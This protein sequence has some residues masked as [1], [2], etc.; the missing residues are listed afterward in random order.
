LEF[1]V[2]EYAHISYNLST[3]Y[4]SEHL[5]YLFG[6]VVDVVWILGFELVGAGELVEF[7]GIKEY[8][9]KGSLMRGPI[10]DR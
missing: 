10:A 6:D 4:V 3:V 7:C 5:V 2:F 8:S 9:M 1:K